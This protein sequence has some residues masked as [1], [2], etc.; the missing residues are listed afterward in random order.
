V[1][2]PQF[3]GTSGQ[4][5]FYLKVV[6]DDDQSGGAT[7]ASGSTG[8][9]G[10]FEW[11][12]GGDGN[13]D[14]VYEYAYVSSTTVPDENRTYMQATEGEPVAVSSSWRVMVSTSTSGRYP[15]RITA[16]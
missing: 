15:D 4:P 14:S 12:N 7:F 11:A 1:V 3:I 9:F 8:M 2:S 13:Q 6:V 10:T 5:D 16:S